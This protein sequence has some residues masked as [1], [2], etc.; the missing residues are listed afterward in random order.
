MTNLK[1][2]TLLNYK[3]FRGGQYEKLDIS[4]QIFG[5]KLHTAPIILVNHA[6]TGNSDL[7]SEEKGWW[8]EIIGDN[9]LINTKKYTVIAFNILG[10]GYDNTLIDNYKDFIAKDIARLFSLVLKELKVNNLY[11]LIGGSIGGGIAWEMTALYPKY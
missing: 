4:Y 11:A 3:T 10:N 5:K 2:H 1:F 7:N 6:L 8:K 9:K